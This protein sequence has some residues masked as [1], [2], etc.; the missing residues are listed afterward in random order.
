MSQITDLHDA[1][2]RRELAEIKAL[3]EA[4]RSLANACSETDVRGTYRFTLR[5]SLVKPARPGC[6]SNMA[7]MSRYWI[8]KMTR[9]PLDGRRS[10]VVPKS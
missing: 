2:K 5:L 3:L 7:Q 1:V 9:S 10:S 4:D 6:Y 8:P